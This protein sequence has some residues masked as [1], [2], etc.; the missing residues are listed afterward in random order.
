MQPLIQ[1]DSTPGGEES[2][3]SIIRKYHRG[4][5]PLEAIINNRD[6]RVQVIYTRI[7]R[8]NTNQPVFTDLSINEDPSLYFYPAST[9]KMP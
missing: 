9:V 6:H 4:S 3:V 1:K 5:L 8:T 2:L 7:N